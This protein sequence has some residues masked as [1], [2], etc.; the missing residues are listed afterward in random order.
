MYQRLHYRI[1]LHLTSTVPQTCIKLN[2]NPTPEQE[3]YFTGIPRLNKHFRLEFKAMFMELAQQDSFTV[4]GVKYVFTG[5]ESTKANLLNT[6]SLDEGTLYPNQM[7]CN[8][9]TV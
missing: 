8:H 6:T 7:P 3:K 9:V 1:Y 4:D 2:P 5:L